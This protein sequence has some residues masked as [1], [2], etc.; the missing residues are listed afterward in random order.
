M[1]VEWAKVDK[2][3]SYMKLAYQDPGFLGASFGPHPMSWY[4]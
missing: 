1:L 2:L 3:C 4:V